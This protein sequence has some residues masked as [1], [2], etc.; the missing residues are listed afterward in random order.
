[1]APSLRPCQPP[2]AAGLPGGAPRDEPLMPYTL[3]QGGRRRPRRLLPVLA[4]F[5]L[6]CALLLAL[7]ASEDPGRRSVAPLATSGPAPLAG[8]GTAPSP[9]AVRLADTRDPVAHSFRHPPRAG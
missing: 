4:A 9:L 5:A 2:P 1:M 7:P 6:A 8:G 3:L